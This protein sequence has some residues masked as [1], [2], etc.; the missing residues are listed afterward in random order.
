M[1]HYSNTFLQFFFIR[2]AALLLTPVWKVQR[3]ENHTGKQLVNSAGLNYNN[4]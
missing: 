2:A 3:T 1:V 4:S